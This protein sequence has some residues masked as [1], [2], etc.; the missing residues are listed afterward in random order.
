MFGESDSESPRVP[1]PWDSLTS[2]PSSP[3]Q[4]G[5]PKLV[6]E[7]EEVSILSCLHNRLIT[8]LSSQGNVEYKLQLLSPSPGRFARLVTQLKW[9]LLEGGGQAYYE[10]G[11]ADSGTLVGL[12]RQQLEESLETLEMMAGE[13]GASVIVVKEIEVPPELSSLAESQLERW[14]GKRSAR[15]KDRLRM[16]IED[17]GSPTT[18]ATEAETEFSNTDV[19]DAEEIACYSPVTSPC[20]PPGES[21]PIQF[22][23]SPVSFPF[24][25]AL[26]VFT[27][28]LEEDVAGHADNGAPVGRRCIRKQD[29]L[30]MKKHDGET[31]IK[32][33]TEVETDLSNIDVTDAEETTSSSLVPP[34]SGKSNLTRLGPPLPVSFPFDPALAMFTMD[35]GED[36][37]DYADSEAPDD[38]VSTDFVAEFPVGLEIST[39]YKPRP[40]KKRATRVTHFEYTK[41]K[42]TNGYPPSKSTHTTG[43][44]ASLTAQGSSE[45]HSEQS[46]AKSQPR[47]DKRDKRRDLKP[48]TLLTHVPTRRSIEPPTDPADSHTT[49]PASTDETNSS[50]PESLT[51][52]VVNSP[53]VDAFGTNTSAVKEPRLIVEALVVR[54]LSLDE[55]FLDFEGFSLQ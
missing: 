24:D 14:N 34:P 23:T 1:S 11:V 22:G 19:T 55:A 26:A 30:M 15:R 37:A 33:V 4:N 54:K 2:A 44:T 17:H 39:V 42:L 48:N 52:T 7:A 8:W 45:A 13:I 47:R 29:T 31:L 6:P 40:M 49:S 5:I 9:R 43:Q 27:M 25:P 50:P 3:K 53:T 16:T 12:P 36:V 10:L 20:S 35:L 38:D 21:N 41:K 28:D 32:S 46:G 18:S 51:T